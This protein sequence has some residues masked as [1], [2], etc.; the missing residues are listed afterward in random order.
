MAQFH[1]ESTKLFKE[2][3]IV[4]MVEDLTEKVAKEKSKWE[5]LDGNFH[6]LEKAV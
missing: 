6:E 5:E 1:I 2:H 3:I 4:Q